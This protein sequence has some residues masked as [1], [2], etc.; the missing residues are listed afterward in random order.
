MLVTDL[1]KPAIL[2][3]RGDEVPCRAIANLIVRLFLNDLTGSQSEKVR[4][5]LATCQACRNRLATLED[6]WEATH[7]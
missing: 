1:E 4:G 5:H 6:A 7:R 3:E 2:T